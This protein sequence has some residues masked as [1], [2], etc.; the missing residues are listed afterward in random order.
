MTYTI[1]LKDLQVQTLIGV[2]EWERASMRPL[3]L[4][5]ELQVSAPKAAGTDAVEDTVDYARIESCIVEHAAGSRYQLLEGFVTSLC[6]LVLVL[7]GRIKQVTIEADKPGILQHARSVSVSV[8]A[9]H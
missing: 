9:R 8:T 6:Q 3:L 7:D 5:V 2:Y 1:R 4:Q